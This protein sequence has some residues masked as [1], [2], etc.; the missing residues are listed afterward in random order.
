MKLDQHKEEVARLQNEQFEDIS[1][2]IDQKNM[3]LAIK[4]F[5]QYSDPIG[6]FIREITSNAYDAH[7]EAGTNKPVV[8]RYSRTKQQIQF[9]DHGTGLSPQLVREVFSKFFSSTK[10]ETNDQIGAFGL[11]SKSPLSYSETIEIRTKYNDRVYTYI[12][13]KGDGIPVLTT[14]S[15]EAYQE[16]TGPWA[17]DENGTEVT[18]PTDQEDHND[19]L[20]SLDKQLAYFDNVVIFVDGVARKND[21]KIFRGKNL[22]VRLNDHESDMFSFNALHICIGKV[23]YPLDITFNDYNRLTT[24]EKQAIQDEALKMVDDPY[25]VHR[26]LDKMFNAPVGLYFDI[27]ELPILWNRENIEY[28]RHVRKKIFIKMLAARYEIMALQHKYNPDYETLSEAL[29]PVQTQTQQE[30]LSEFLSSHSIQSV[31]GYE[32]TYKPYRDILK[33]VNKITNSDS[34]VKPM[35][36]IIKHLFDEHRDSS[37]YSPGTSYLWRLLRGQEKKDLYR[38]PEGDTRKR[39]LRAYVEETMKSSVASIRLN[40]ADTLLDNLQID[41]TDPQLKEHKKQM[42]QIIT[43]LYDQAKQWYNQ[44]PHINDIEIPEWFIDNSAPSAATA[45]VNDVH[46]LVSQWSGS[47]RSIYAEEIGR[48]QSFIYGFTDERENLN[49]TG[50]LLQSLA[51]SRMF[52]LFKEPSYRE[53]YSTETAIIGRQNVAYLAKKWDMI[54]WSELV[55][56][57]RFLTKYLTYI[58]AKKYLKDRP[59]FVTF[60]QHWNDRIALTHISRE[61]VP[62]FTDDV[63]KDLLAVYKGH[64]YKPEFDLDIKKLAMTRKYYNPAALKYLQRLY[65]TFLKYG[66]YLTLDGRLP[67]QWTEYQAMRISEII[68]HE[69]NPTLIAKLYDSKKTFDSTN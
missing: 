52:A 44:L 10:R 27:G 14:L 53:N 29:S 41:R 24:E 11:G 36:S 54:H 28:D 15:D 34:Y 66:P 50:K 22:I 56:S 9:I 35:E 67:S 18:V 13:H 16:H 60:L 63:V 4:A 6:S 49:Q 5:Y 12:V 1:Y 7:I 47:Y 8:V 21:Y 37:S 46:M 19:I 3:G 20:V 39:Y 64:L 62:E 61:L 32:S 33:E 30:K 69:I 43:D 68:Q 55:Y 45:P 25:P 58:L 40:S 57:R 17:K 65:G 23:Y 42:E 38:Y 59:M 48:R 2:G 26:T 51:D 31:T